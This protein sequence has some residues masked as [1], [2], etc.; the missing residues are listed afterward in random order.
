MDL[1]KLRRAEGGAKIDG[2]FHVINHVFTPK[3]HIFSNF[4][5]ETPGAPPG[6]APN[7]DEIAGFGSNLAIVYILRLTMALSTTYY[8]ND[9]CDNQLFSFLDMTIL[10]HED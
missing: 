1:K 6:S 3:N 5:G 2:V 10:C 4:R 7:Y 8:I 9:C